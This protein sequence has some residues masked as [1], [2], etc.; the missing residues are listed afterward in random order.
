MHVDRA[1]GTTRPKPKG[2]LIAGR[3][4]GERKV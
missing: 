2:C 1:Y 4:N 3:H